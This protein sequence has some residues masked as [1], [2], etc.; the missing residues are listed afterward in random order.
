M[1]LHKYADKIFSADCMRPGI[2]IGE[3][4]RDE[5]GPMNN[6]PDVNKYSLYESDEGNWR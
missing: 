4:K 2:G 5:L 6:R 3:R 1:T